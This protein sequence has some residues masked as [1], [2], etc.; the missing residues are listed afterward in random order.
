MTP[1]NIPQLH[2]LESLKPSPFFGI[3]PCLWIVGTNVDFLAHP[4]QFS[5]EKSFYVGVVL[6]LA[7]GGL[8]MIRNDN[9]AFVVWHWL[10]LL[11]S[12]GYLKR[13][14]TDKLRDIFNKVRHFNF[15]YRLGFYKW[16]SS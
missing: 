13:A 12:A 1:H 7:H 11:Q 10:C 15:L 5:G 6:V 3:I 8:F 9:L 14:K 4:C 16:Q 2:R